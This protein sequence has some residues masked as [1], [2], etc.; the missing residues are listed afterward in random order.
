MLHTEFAAEGALAST[1]RRS[2]KYERK[3][4][5]NAASTSPRRERDNDRRFVRAP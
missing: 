3:K 1:F 5:H 4:P 2:R